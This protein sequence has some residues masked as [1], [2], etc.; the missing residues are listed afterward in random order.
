MLKVIN[1]QN[2]N[3]P[4][5]YH[6]TYLC[7]VLV[8]I[9]LILPPIAIHIFPRTYTLH[10]IHH[11][12]IR[13]MHLCHQTSNS[14][15]YVVESSSRSVCRKNKL[16]GNQIEFH[17]WE[18]E[19]SEKWFRG[20]HVDVALPCY[21]LVRYIYTS[22]TLLRTD[23]SSWTDTRRRL[24]TSDLIHPMKQLDYISTLWGNCMSIR[25]HLLGMCPFIMYINIFWDQW[26]DCSS[27]HLFIYLSHSPR[28]QHFALLNKRERRT[29]QRQVPLNPIDDLYRSRSDG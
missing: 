12:Y 15:V 5:W 16:K 21:Q 2:L 3:P 18:L 14:S 4:C 24:F 28:Y 26:N 17:D 23:V 7:D 10:A 9:Y 29:T 20:S 1:Y 13:G 6:T 25:T 22:L 11:W 19:T 8:H 27:I